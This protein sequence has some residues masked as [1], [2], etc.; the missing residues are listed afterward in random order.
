MRKYTTETQEKGFKAK[1]FD[2]LIQKWRLL[3]FI[4]LILLFFIGA[5]GGRAEIQME[6]KPVIEAENFEIIKYG[7]NEAPLNVREQM[8]VESKWISQYPRN[9]T[10]A[11]LE[12]CGEWYRVDGGFVKSEYVFDSID[13]YRHG[14]ILANTFIYPNPKT[15]T[16][17][18]GTVSYDN[19]E[20]FIRKVNGF[21]E[22]SSGGFVKE[23]F[24]TFDYFLESQIKPNVLTLN[25][26]KTYFMP[27]LPI[28]YLGTLFEKSSG[29]G[30]TNK[31]CLFFRGDIPIYDIIDGYAYFPSGQHIYK[32]SIDKFSKIQNVGAD[33]E[34]LA[35]YRTV[36]YTSPWEREYNIGLVSEYLD[37]TI[38][39]AGKTFSYNKTTGPRSES[40]GYKL[41]NTI[42]N[43]EI[44]LDYGG[45]VC[46]VSSTIYASILNH[47]NFKVTA[48]KKHGG[49][50]V[51]YLPEGM[52][53]TVSYG[54][55]DFKFM[56]DNPFAVRLNVKSENNICLVTIT[57]VN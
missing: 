28:Q 5:Q 26:M 45:G 24:V 33:Y 46:Q 13:I 8:D 56:N 57:R 34:I 3:G 48:R 12:D 27:V 25:D 31:S 2:F 37:G 6:A 1:A 35:A 17:K 11:I 18:F 43:G 55:V 41:A 50:G 23:E 19:E 36:Y 38:I 39:P 16:E 53:A 52:D 40:M 49:D 32:I 15:S 20:L 14:K 30:V 51:S 22:L 9:S 7:Y 29:D 54:A 42:A 10:I 44:V 4:F 21:L 47:D